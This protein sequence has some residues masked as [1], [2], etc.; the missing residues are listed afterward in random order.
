MIS[1]ETPWKGRL[2]VDGPHPTL[3]LDSELRGLGIDLPDPLGKA[4]ATSRPLHLDIA[5]ADRTRLS[6]RLGSNLGLRWQQGAP[7]RGQVWIGRDAPSDW[8][9]EPGWS[10]QAYLPRLAPAAWGSALSPLIDG[11]RNGTAADV[12]VSRVTLDTDCLSVGERCL[13]SLIVDGGPQADGW[14]LALDGSLLSGRLEYRPR[15][16]VPLDIRLDRLRLDD[17]VPDD[18]VAATSQDSG[19]LFQELDVPPTPIPMPDGIGK[20][21]AGQLSVESLH[22]QSS[23]FGPFSANWRTSPDQ[24][25]LDPVSLSLGEIDARGNLTWEASGPEASLT[26]SRLSL[27][28]AMSARHCGPWNS[29]WQ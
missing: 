2:G 29:R 15:R 4:P 19:Q 28:G 16:H 6:G 10:V 1:G 23:T 9:A 12:G 18:S 26:R 27:E 13:G 17:L 21:P 11:G 22:W 20:V 14:R 25:V 24:L 8:P 3:T 5:L 7:G